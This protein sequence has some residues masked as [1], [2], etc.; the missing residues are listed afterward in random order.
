MP[1][2]KALRE[3]AVILGAADDPYPIEGMVFVANKGS[4]EES[5]QTLLLGMPAPRFKLVRRVTIGTP[6]FLYDM[7]NL[8]RPSL[9]FHQY[10]RTSRNLPSSCWNPEDQNEW[11]ARSISCHL[12]PV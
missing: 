8:V 6:I 3:N 9:P 12:L 5:L 1:R 10:K 7:H 11:S 2:G 4:I